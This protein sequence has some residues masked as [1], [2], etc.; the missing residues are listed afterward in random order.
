MF[1]IDFDDN[2][3]KS[4]LRVLQYTALSILVILGTI[5]LVYAGQGYDL[6]T[7]TGRV[8]R[9]GLILVNSTPDDAAVSINGQ[10]EPDLTPGSFPVP[11]GQYDIA[12]AKAGY[13]DWHKTVLVTGSEVEWLY[14]PLLVPSQLVTRNLSVFLRPQFV[15]LSPSGDRLLVRQSGRDDPVFNLINFSGGGV[16]NEQSLTLPD[17]LLTLGAG[18]NLGVFD[19]EGWASDNRHILLTHTVGRQV[20]Y[21][22]LDS[23]TVAES[24]NLSE[25][26]DLALSDVRFIDGDSQ[27]L[28]AVV[29]ND[30]R[31][32]DLGRDTISTPIVRDLG[33]YVLYQDQIVV[34]VREV[35]SGGSE[36]G[37]IE[38]DDQPQL[39]R[40][41]PLKPA[42]YRLE[43]AQFE[44]I[45][46]LALL[47]LEQQRLSLT[48]NPNL[49]ELGTAQS[50]LVFNLNGA[51]SIAF[52]RNGQF[53]SVQADE[54]FITYDLDRKRR[55]SFKTDFKPAA[56]VEA[57]WLDGFHLSMPDSQG[58]L[59]MFEFDGA[60]STG[61]LA[62]NANLE[63]IY[64]SGQNMLYT[65]SPA[66]QGGRV[67]LQGTSFTVPESQ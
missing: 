4:T 47:D 15:G 58:L 36:L 65:F 63:P 13:R 12:I 8:I 33:R 44:D 41:L 62:V 53:I 38:G 27:R 57:K 26:F 14:Y 5:I 39:L 1:N 50:P 18:Q 55:S 10:I 34:Y 6:N 35:E 16:T 64:N 42:N 61:L 25:D 7:S 59:R 45:F 20:E 52:S 40:N 48:A 23:E 67:F 28:Y 60:N 11:G 29:N 31:L 56:D 54:R 43:F 19:F 22:W 49:A 24:R 46:Y 17:S 9:N 37:L 3:V 51:Q 21:I 2:R 30:L 32:I 66:A